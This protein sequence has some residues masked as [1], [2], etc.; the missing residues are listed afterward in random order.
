VSYKALVKQVSGNTTVVNSFATNLQLQDSLLKA[1]PAAVQQMYNS[2]FYKAF[3]GANNT[4]TASNIWHYLKGHIKYTKDPAGLQYIML[5]ARFAKRQ[6]G[7]CKNYAL[8]TA[9][10]LGSLGLPVFFDFTNYVSKQGVEP[11]DKT[12]PSHVYI[13][14]LSES[15]KRII[16]DAVYNKFNK[17]KPYFY[18]KTVPM[19]IAVLSGVNEL[20][21]PAVMKIERNQIT[22]P[23]KRKEYQ[24]RVIKGEIKKLLNSADP[25]KRAKGRA[26]LDSLK[27]NT[28]QGIYGKKKKKDR[29]SIIKKAGLVGVRNA[30][31]LL[32][33]L[34]V[35]GTA[36]KLSLLLKKPGGE[37]KLKKAWVKKL[38]GEF[39]NL[40]KNIELGKKKKPL[41]GESKKTKGLKGYYGIAEP[42][43]AVSLGAILASAAGAIAAIAPL[44]KSININ[45]EGAESLTPAPGTDSTDLLTDS[46]NNGGTPNLPGDTGTDF[47]DKK[48]LGLPMPVVLLAAA[49]GAYL[50]T[51]K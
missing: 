5:P 12:T 16:I 43:T 36:H 21:T 11:V 15:G 18:K 41:L 3:K 2:G 42:V 38:G 51:K 8:F 46:V 23:V 50:I 10:V 7:D 37:E 39:S 49:G 35:R 29:P 24:A 9:S 34:N 4:E 45:K 13:S 14:T 22:D 27:P 48:V 26:Y 1:Y 40:L 19:K 17:E 33:K 28:M 31:L 30:Y 20:G 47:L 44:L 25:A 6:K 32:V